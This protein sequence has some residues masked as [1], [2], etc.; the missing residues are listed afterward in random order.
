MSWSS[1]CIYCGLSTGY[2]QQKGR[3]LKS[4]AETEGVF[5]LFYTFSY[6]EKHDPYLDRLY[7]GKK[8]Q[9]KYCCPHL[10]DD[11]Y[12]RR[13]QSFRKH[14]LYGTMNA[15]GSWDRDEWQGIMI[16]YHSFIHSHD[17]FIRSIYMLSTP[18]P[19]LLQV[20]TWFIHMVWVRW[21]IVWAWKNI[22]TR[23]QQRNMSECK[24]KRVAMTL[25]LIFGPQFELNRKEN[26]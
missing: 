18:L 9:Q 4:L 1:F 21:S 2:W 16:V 22:M 7:Q 8:G 11:L 15:T 6:P 12:T 10:I 5:D 13:L 26:L 14:W 20:E 3:L 24:R 19:P 23:Q 17:T 25:L